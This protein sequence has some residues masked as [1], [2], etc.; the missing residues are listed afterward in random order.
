MVVYQV[1]QLAPKKAK[2]KINTPWHLWKAQPHFWKVIYTYF[3]HE[4]N[5][6]H[7]IHKFLEISGLDE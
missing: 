7:S 1:S 3:L 5:K 6:A 2:Y 4:N